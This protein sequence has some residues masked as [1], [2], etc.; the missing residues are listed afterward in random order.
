M[1]TKAEKQR[2][3][4][5]GQFGCIACLSEGYYRWADVHHLLSGGRRIGHEAT[6]PLCEYHHRGVPICR[7]ADGNLSKKAT[8]EVL[9]PC[10]DQKR[11]FVEK[12]GGEQ[13]LLSIIDDV[14][15]AWQQERFF[16]MPQGIRE[17][18]KTRLEIH[19]Q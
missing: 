1:A 6:I 14:Y 19:R 16:G 17:K 3:E 8:Y 11:L 15:S 2:M 10:L 18:I 4:F 13:F 7:N 9:G 12:Y 5:L